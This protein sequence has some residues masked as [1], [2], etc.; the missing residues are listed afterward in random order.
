[1]HSFLPRR[2][3]RPTLFPYPPLFRSSLAEHRAAALL[4]VGL[5]GL[6]HAQFQRRGTRDS[7]GAPAAARL[8][9]EPD[10]AKLCRRAMAITAGFGDRK[11]TS[12]LQSR[13]DL[14]CRLLLEK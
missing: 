13:F 10:G 4:T 6:R 1:P 8:A 3:P 2:P 7:R 14:V 12:E 9:G 11:H 5:P